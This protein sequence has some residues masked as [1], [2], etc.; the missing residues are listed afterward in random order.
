[1]IKTCKH[2]DKHYCTECAK[3]KTPEDFC[4]DECDDLY[5]KNSYEPTKQLKEIFSKTVFLVEA[6]DF[7]RHALWEKWHDEF[8]IWTQASEGDMQTI[9]YVTVQ[10]KI[11]PIVLSFLRTFISGH[12]VMFYYPSSQSV[13][14]EVVDKWIKRYCNP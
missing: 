11:K 5:Y 9:G 7:E 14:Y 4:S 10:N 1:M 2:C 12:Q 3:N 6:T 13:D 8:G